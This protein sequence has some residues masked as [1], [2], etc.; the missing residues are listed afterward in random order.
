MNSVCNIRHIYSEDFTLAAVDDDED[1][2][3]IMGFAVLFAHSIFSLSCWCNNNIMTREETLRENQRCCYLRLMKDDLQAKLNASIV[4][5]QGCWGLSSLWLLLTIIRMSIWRW[6]ITLCRYVLNS[7]SIS[8][9]TTQK[10]VHS[11]NC[12]ES[13]PTLPHIHTKL[14]AYLLLACLPDSN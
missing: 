14:Q 13:K 10:Q 3:G 6:A 8:T 9:C 1:A 12:F 11:I 4:A 5:S 2:C 7:L